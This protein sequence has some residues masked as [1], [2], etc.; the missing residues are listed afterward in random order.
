[1]PGEEMN[2]E[3][4]RISEGVFP[5]FIEFLSG[6]VESTFPGSVYDTIYAHTGPH[7]N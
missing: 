6:N 4:A 5:D 3:Q 7:V 1:M 2:F